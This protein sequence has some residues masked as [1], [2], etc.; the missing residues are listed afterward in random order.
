MFCSWGKPSANLV[1][2]LNDP[3]LG[4]ESRCALA[5]SLVFGLWQRT[6]HAHTH[7]PPSLLWINGGKL[8]VDPFSSLVRQFD[9]QDFDGKPVKP[10]VGDI[11]DYSRVA[12]QTMV[13]Y[14]NQRSR[15]RHESE[16]E[17][18]VKLVGPQ[19]SAAKS[20]RFGSGV[21]GSYT[22]RW[23]HQL[24]LVT[25]AQDNAVLWLNSAED[26]ER[27]RS[28]L[29]SNPGRLTAP[30]G[31][32][33]QFLRTRKT[34]SM[35]GA[36]SPSH[37]DAALGEDVIKQGLPLLFLP[38]VT[39][40]IVAIPGESVVGMIGVGFQSF[41]MDRT[42]RINPGLKL[43][44][45]PWVETYERILR[46]RCSKLPGSYE[47]FIMRTFRELGVIC[48]RVAALVAE[49]GLPEEC[50]RDLSADLRLMTT[51]ALVTSVY[52]L[53]Y[54]GWGIE[55][56]HD[57]AFVFKILGWLRSIE[58][59]DR[60]GFQR[61]FPKLAAP[62]RDNLLQTLE[63]HGLIKN[64]G[65]RIAATSFPEFVKKIP[66]L[67][68]LPNLDLQTER[69]TKLIRDVE[70]GALDKVASGQAEHER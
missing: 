7:Q 13:G 37:W 32:N 51:R 30:Y 48:D 21:T 58:G 49:D 65:S 60:R 29:K 45:A 20:R 42:S 25:D 3:N 8:P 54:H 50:R 70:G 46:E 27:L 52:G 41:W 5:A 34:M 14:I 36:L 16:A 38:H 47:F 18:L 43:R 9:W 66:G 55:T 64:E 11:P 22:M 53:G 68:G 4:D 62:A 15:V 19:W 67:A 17:G 40:S 44:P 57:R 35:N 2:A 61:R 31:F 33:S 28:D 63:L 1:K 10:D 6:G 59:I 69:L 23:D 26:W 56:G 39:N 12:Y 24:G